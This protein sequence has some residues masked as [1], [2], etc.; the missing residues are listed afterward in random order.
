MSASPAKHGGDAELT[1][2]FST[3]GVF[4]CVLDLNNKKLQ[5][6]LNYHR[7]KTLEELAANK[8][9]HTHSLR[10]SNSYELCEII[11]LIYQKIFVTIQ[12]GQYSEREV[13]PAPHFRVTRKPIKQLG[14]CILHQNLLCS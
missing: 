5:R 9:V 11:R 7:V 10:A 3:K 1:L 12:S 6:K 4:I 2:T 14:L 13:L 8:Y